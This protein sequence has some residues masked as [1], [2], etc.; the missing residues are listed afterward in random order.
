MAWAVEIDSSE[1]PSAS[2]SSAHS[3]AASSLPSDALIETSNRVPAL[4]SGS[5]E[6]AIASRAAAGSR[7][8][9]ASHQRAA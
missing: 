2:S 5:S 1:K 3:S 6:P 8:S 9:S 4:K 7:G